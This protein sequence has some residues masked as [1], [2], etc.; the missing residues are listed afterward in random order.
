V[1]IET[2]RNQ[3]METSTRRRGS[4]HVTAYSPGMVELYAT[5]NCNPVTV[6]FPIAR[7]SVTQSPETPVASAYWL[8]N[9]PDTYL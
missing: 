4:E 5:P 1:W 8:L 9:P 3:A 7:L 6:V 2:Q